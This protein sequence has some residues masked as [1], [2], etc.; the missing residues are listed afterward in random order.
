[1]NKNSKKNPKKKYG[2]TMHPIH[3]TG[4]RVNLCKYPP[5]VK[6]VFLLG[7]LLV[8]EQHSSQF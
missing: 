3:N 6:S 7:I 2:E 4:F 8:K 5:E 1:M